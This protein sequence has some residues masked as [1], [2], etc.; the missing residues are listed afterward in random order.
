MKK[1][2]VIA[3]FIA[4]HAF[5]QSVTLDPSNVNTMLTLVKTG[6]GLDHRS[7]NNLVGLGTYGSPTGGFIQTHSNYPLSF[8]TNNG[9]TQMV[10]LTNGNFGIGTLTPTYKLHVAGGAY[11]SSDFNCS[12]TTSSGTI[13]IGGGATISK[14]LE[15][16]LFSQSITALNANTCNTQLYNANGLALND[17][18]MFNLEGASTTNIVVANVRAYNNQLEV[19]FCNLGTTPT[20]AQTVNMK[21]AIIR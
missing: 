2:V 3:V 21:V 14:Y 6:I 1:L 18:V 8:A 4:N 7:T 9:S 11:F 19:K 17:G 10:L 16:S 15:L 12:S 5:G 20:T 13:Q